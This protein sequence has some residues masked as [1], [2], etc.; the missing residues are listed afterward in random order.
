MIETTDN[1]R[2][3]RDFVSEQIEIHA[4]KEIDIEHVPAT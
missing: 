2:S 3:K 4:A 1:R